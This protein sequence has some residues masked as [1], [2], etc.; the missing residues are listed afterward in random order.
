LRDAVKV[1]LEAFCV[2]L[3]DIKTSLIFFRPSN[4]IT[5]SCHR[6]YIYSSGADSRV[7]SSASISIGAQLT[8]RFYA[9]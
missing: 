1:V 5:A 4:M 3:P 8:R 7:M 9:G 2:P 6:K